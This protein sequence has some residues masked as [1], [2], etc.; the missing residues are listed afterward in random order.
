MCQY[1]ANFNPPAVSNLNPTFGPL[2]GGE[3]VTVTGAGFEDTSGTADVAGVQV[4][5]ATA[6]GLTVVS[7]T[8]LQAT[9]PPAVTTTPPASPTPPKTVLG[10]L[11][12]SSP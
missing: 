8:V 4:G 6:T 12:S 1:R 7:K 3:V 10:R 5:S 11:R 2:A 9:L